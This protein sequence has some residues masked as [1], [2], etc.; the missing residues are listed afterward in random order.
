VL[1]REV[2]LAM[3]LEARAG[4]AL[5]QRRWVGMTDFG[6]CEVEEVKTT[7][8]TPDSGRGGLFIEEFLRFTAPSPIIPLLPLSPPKYL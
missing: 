6:R 1:L 2:K 4:V 8:G 5:T 7:R 3:F